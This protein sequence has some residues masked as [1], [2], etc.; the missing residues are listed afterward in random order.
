M[1]TV[2][3]IGGGHIVTSDG[4]G[5]GIEPDHL[6]RI[7]VGD[8]FEAF[9][10]GGKP[11]GL[12]SEI[13][14]VKIN[15]EWLW[16][17]TDEQVET[18]RRERKTTYEREESER[19]AQS[20]ADYA[21]KLAA[22]PL[23]FDW[24]LEG[25]SPQAAAALD[26]VSDE[27]EFPYTYSGQSWRYVYRLWKATAETPDLLDDLGSF[28]EVPGVQTDDLGLSGFMESWARNAVRQMRGK[29]PKGNSA[30]VTVGGVDEDEMVPS[31]GS[32]ESMM[33]AVI[34]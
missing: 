23:A 15:G 12:G 32:A 5:I 9:E 6:S 3:E 34:G 24:D 11:A 19:E 4:W 18:E 13:T 17:K 25:P 22:D 8:T 14:G 27:S 33:K 30:I 31:R 2:T 7:K 26:R 20:R 16:H 1:N 10:M 28:D 29:L 21:A